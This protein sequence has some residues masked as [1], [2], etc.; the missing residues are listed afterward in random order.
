MCCTTRLCQAVVDASAREPSP[1]L[2]LTNI[3]D[4]VKL[5]H[6]QRAC[7]EV[8]SPPSSFIPLLSIFFLLLRLRAKVANA[9]C[10]VL[11]ERKLLSGAAVLARSGAGAAWY[12]GRA[13]DSKT[14]FIHATVQSVSAQV[15]CAARAATCVCYLL[16]RALCDAWYE[17]IIWLFVRYHDTMPGLAVLR[18]RLPRQHPDTVTL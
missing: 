5:N 18:Q 13:A 11:R 12:W 2:P 17:G 9:A 7:L 10:P 14:T 6:T 8:C 3:P 4:S 1:L 15:S 16:L